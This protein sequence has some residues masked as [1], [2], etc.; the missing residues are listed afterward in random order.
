MH[1]RRPAFVKDQRLQ[2]WMAFDLDAVEIV[3]FALVPCGSG[4]DRGSG[5]RARPW[6]GSLKRRYSRLLHVEEVVHPAG[7][8]VL[9]AA[10][11]GDQSASVRP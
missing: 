7:A 5:R 1:I 2:I 3:Q 9:D 11:D 6:T 4:R 8:V 10:E